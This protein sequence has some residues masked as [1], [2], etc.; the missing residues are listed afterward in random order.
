MKLLLTSST[1]ARAYNDCY[2][3]ACDCGNKVHISSRSLRALILAISVFMVEEK[4]KP[5]PSCA[6]RVNLS[7][8]K[9]VAAGGFVSRVKSAKILED[10][11]KK[12]EQ[13]IDEAKASRKVIKCNLKGVAT[14][15]FAPD[16]MVD[17]MPADSRRA[18]SF[19][20]PPHRSIE[21]RISKKF[22]EKDKQMH[23]YKEP[24]VLFLYTQMIDRQSVS[25]LF[26]HS[27]DNVA[28]TMASYPKLSGLVLVVSH[29]SIQRALINW[30]SE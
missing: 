7:F 12:M 27:M 4:K 16:D 25:N 3:D 14:I 8:M 18:F 9:G 24:W 10:L 6:R 1:S 19:V 13:S 15:Y 22:E 21:E 23:H 26:D 17:Q 20:Q 11:L 28:V 5:I 2:N 30:L 29:L